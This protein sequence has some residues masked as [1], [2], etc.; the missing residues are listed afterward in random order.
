MRAFAGEGLDFGL[1][2]QVWR[3]I[4]NKVDTKPGCTAD[5]DACNDGQVQQHA[6]PRLLAV[7]SIT[8]NQPTAACSKRVLLQNCFGARVVEQARRDAR[9]NVR[10]EGAAACVARSKLQ[11][12]HQIGESSGVERFCHLGLQPKVQ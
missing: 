5:P 12:V 11:L 6:A 8:A 9:H 1:W 3:I 4:F 10:A 2:G 7:S